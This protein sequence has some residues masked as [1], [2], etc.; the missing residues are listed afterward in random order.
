MSRRWRITGLLAGGAMVRRAIERRIR[1]KRA[2]VPKAEAVA[3]GDQAVSQRA[4]AFQSRI[5]REDTGG[6]VGS[7]TKP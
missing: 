1:E 7:G 3:T 6:Q 4:V 5:K 2:S